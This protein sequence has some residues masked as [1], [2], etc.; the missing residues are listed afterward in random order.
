MYNITTLRCIYNARYDSYV[1]LESPLNR[2]PSRDKTLDSTYYGN[3]IILYVFL[4]D[5]KCSNITESLVHDVQAT[6]AP[7][8]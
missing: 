3:V 5:T 8:F 4:F 2:S 1:T 6:V 7:M